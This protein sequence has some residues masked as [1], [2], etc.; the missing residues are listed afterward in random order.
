M[1]QSEQAKDKQLEQE[2]LAFSF[3]QE[4][5]RAAVSDRI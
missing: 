2:L 3:R 1:N 5:I 4:A